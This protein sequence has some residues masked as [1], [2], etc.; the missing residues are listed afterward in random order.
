MPRGP[1]HAERPRCRPKAAPRGKVHV[2]LPGTAL[3]LDDQGNPRV[4]GSLMVAPRSHLLLPAEQCCSGRT[5][6]LI[7][8][9]PRVSPEAPALS[10]G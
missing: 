4:C 2:P 7:R 1:S 6:P 8:K 3:R 9:A 10:A 5:G